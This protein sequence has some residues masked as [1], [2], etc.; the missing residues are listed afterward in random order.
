ME[1][2]GD[3]EGLPAVVVEGG[4]DDPDTGVGAGDPEASLASR[5]FNAIAL[6]VS[7][8]LHGVGIPK[9]KETRERTTYRLRSASALAPPGPG[10]EVYPPATGSSHPWTSFI[11]TACLNTKLAPK[12]MTGLVISF[13]YQEGR[14]AYLM[15]GGNQY[16][17]AKV[18]LLSP[19][20]S[21]FSDSLKNRR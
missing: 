10:R 8:F 17:K 7:F 20:N 18:S 12:L 6:G 1:V 14:R 21:P 9:R 15:G 13:V 11:R 5:A 16:W 19:L 2:V 4:A 3:V